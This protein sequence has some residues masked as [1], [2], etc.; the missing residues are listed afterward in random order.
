MSDQKRSIPTPMTPEAAARIQSQAAKS[1]TNQGFASRAQRAAAK[2]SQAGKPSG[3][4]G[5][6]R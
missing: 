3:A 5:G 1:G 4:K 2:H 6:K